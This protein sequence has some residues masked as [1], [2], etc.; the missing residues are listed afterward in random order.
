MERDIDRV[1]ELLIGSDV[2][3]LEGEAIE[4]TQTFRD[5]VAEFEDDLETTLEENTH[6]DLDEKERGSIQAVVDLSPRAVAEY[7]ALVDMT[8]DELTKTERTWVVS[9]LDTFGPDPIEDEGSPELFTP[10]SGDKVPFLARF[11]KKM[12]LYCW[13]HDCD[14]CEVVKSDFEQIFT[15]SPDEMALFSV[16]GP[17]ASRLLYEEYQVSGGPTTLFFYNGRVD[18]RL[19]G[20]SYPTSLQSEIETLR[21]M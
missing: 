18:V 12:I 1:F 13:R 15:E 17:S 4:T 3:Q 8:G 19:I 10:V 16:F 11:Y 5:R 9:S 2:V 20:A 7:L 14:P 6:P 21:E